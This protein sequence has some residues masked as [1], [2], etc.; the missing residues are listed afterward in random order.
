MLINIRVKG[1]EFIVLKVYWFF[2][3]YEIING[4]GIGY[5]FIFIYINGIILRNFILNILFFMMDIIG[6]EIWMNYIIKM[7]VFIVMG[8]GFWSDF[9]KEDI[10][11]EGKLVVYY[12]N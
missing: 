1:I 2:V 5:K 9:L 3:F 11:E 10:D 4:I 6:L 12:L 7:I 8:D